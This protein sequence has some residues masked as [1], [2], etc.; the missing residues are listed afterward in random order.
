MTEREKYK[1]YLLTCKQTHTNPESFN[2]WCFLTAK[3]ED[4]K[5]FVDRTIAK[6]KEYRQQHGDDV[7]INPGKKKW[8]NK[9]KR[10]IFSGEGSSYA[11]IDPKFIQAAKEL[12]ELQ[13]EKNESDYKWMAEKQF[14][15]NLQ[16]ET[17]FF[18]PY[19][20][21]TKQKEETIKKLKGPKKKEK[22]GIFNKLLQ[23]IQKGPELAKRPLYT[24]QQW[25]EKKQLE[26][27]KDEC[28]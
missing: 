23:L 10:F 27:I 5:P 4:L 25:K 1:E 7:L 9:E 8:D 20:E 24:K 12:R 2:M 16:K 28:E 11:K 3:Y 22:K 14:S 15:D 13:K 17:E 6:N 19:T 21:K 26:K 18:H